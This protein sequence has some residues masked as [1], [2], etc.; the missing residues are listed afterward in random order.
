MKKFHL[1]AALFLAW[2]LAR[3]PRT[4]QAWVGVP[5]ASASRFTWVRAPIITATAILTPTP[6]IIRR[7]SSFPRRRP[8]CRRRRRINCPR[9][10]PCARP[11]SLSQ[12]HTAGA[13]CA[14][15][16]HRSG[17]AG[18]RQHH[19]RQRQGDA[20]NR[21]PRPTTFGPQRHGPPRRRSGARPHESRVA[22]DAI[23][24]VLQ[25]DNSPIARDG[26]ARSLGLMGSSQ[27]MRALIYAAQADNDR[28]VRHSAQF[29]IEVIRSNLRGN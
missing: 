3:L 12:Q 10:R 21:C 9:R 20:A 4:H 5:S 14:S 29:A 6:T 22:I 8:S 25:K 19:P 17:R 1:T 23:T 18:N 11:P 13:L 28:D 2:Q 15:R 16:P 7:P 27:A 26:A 24:N